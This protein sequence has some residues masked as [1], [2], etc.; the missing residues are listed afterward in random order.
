MFDFWAPLDER[1]LAAVMGLARFQGAPFYN[2][3][4]S[5]NFFGDVPYGPRIRSLSLEQ[6]FG[7]LYQKAIPNLLKGG[8]TVLGDSM[9]RMLGEAPAADRD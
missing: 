7:V 4:W 2:F 3:F 5:R 1:F 6:A 8:L 9:K